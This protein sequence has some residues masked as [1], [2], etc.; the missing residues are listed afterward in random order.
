LIDKRKQR[1]KSKE[2][3]ST[4]KKWSTSFVRPVGKKCFPAQQELENSNWKPKFLTELS[5]AQTIP[6]YYF[7]LP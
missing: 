1:K 3:D 6:F 7:W 5:F 2:F 4:K